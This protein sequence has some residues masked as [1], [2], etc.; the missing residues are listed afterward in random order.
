MRIFYHSIRR[1]DWTAYLWKPIVLIV[2]ATRSWCL[3]AQ[4]AASSHIHSRNRRRGMGFW[5]RA[6][7]CAGVLLMAAS[8]AQAQVQTGSITGNVTDSS[9]AVLPGGTVSLSGEQ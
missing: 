2:H 3:R 8:I 7:S 5:R 1:I 9:G 6:L 4:S